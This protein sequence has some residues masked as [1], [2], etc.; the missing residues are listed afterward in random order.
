LISEDNTESKADIKPEQPEFSLVLGGPLFRLFQKTHLSNDLLELVQRRIIII[1]AIAWLPLFLLSAISGRLLSRDDSLPFLL[2]ADIHIRFLVV[3][4]L[5]VAAELFVHRQ[6][7]H[8]VKQ[9]DARGL[10]PESGRMLFKNAVSSAVRWR[11][12]AAAEILLLAVVYIVGVL[13]IWRNYTSIQTASWYSTGL[14]E[15]SKLTSAGFWYGYVSIPLFQFLLLRWYFR[16]FVWIKFLWQVS[17]IKLNLVAMHP[18]RVGGLGFLSV[19][20]YAFVP[21]VIAHGALLA[22]YIANRILYTGGS[23]IDFKIE[24]VSVL[25]FLFI[26]VMGPLFVFSPMLARAKRKGKREYG[27]LAMRYVRE[28]D[29]KWLR[30]GA[31]EGEQLIGSGDIQSL[32][33]LGNS[34]EV[35]KGMHLTPVTKEVVFQLVAAALVPILPLV[36]TLMPLGELFNKLIGIIF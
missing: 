11:N 1:S 3:V 2:D 15:G 23:L 30:G 27:F 33:D 36:L 32:A 13:I 19:S 7:R 8:L 20:V 29:T 21:F 25:I 14:S 35:V 34:F 26:I 22:G 9:F 16:L 5:L 17:G 31:P 24:I 12:S 10:I 4:P 28:F 18:D 6:M